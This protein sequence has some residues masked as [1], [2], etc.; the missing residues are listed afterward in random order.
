MRS[1]GLISWTKVAPELLNFRIPGHF[2]SDITGHLQS[3]HLFKLV[4]NVEEHDIILMRAGKFDFPTHST[5]P[6]GFA[7]TT[8]IIGAH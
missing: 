3:C 7:Q 8:D 2:V 4:G 1:F 6:C 5:S